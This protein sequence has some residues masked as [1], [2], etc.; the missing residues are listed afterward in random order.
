MTTTWNDNWSIS[1]I[2]IWE[3]AKNNWKRIEHIPVCVEWCD[4]KNQVQTRV[5]PNHVI[6]Y[7]E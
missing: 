2:F 5:N 3:Y 6:F 1:V 7:L 4:K